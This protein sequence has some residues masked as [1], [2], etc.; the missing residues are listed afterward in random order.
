MIG[1]L[2]KAITSARQLGSDA[3]ESIEG[4]ARDIG[5]SALGAVDAVKAATA[6]AL[7]I[8]LI[9]AEVGVAVAAVVAPVPVLVGLALLWLYEDEIAQTN[10][11]IDNALSMRG[12][13]RNRERAIAMLKKYGQIPETAVL[14]TPFVEMKITNS[15]QQVEGSIKRGEFEGAQLHSLSDTDLVRLIASC[16]DEQSRDILEGYQSLRQAQSSA[17]S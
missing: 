17:S 5:D 13:V 2:S 6:K 4:R 16:P 7:N 11:S 1:S 10:K 14:A 15:T 8:T 9:L 3:A 12:A